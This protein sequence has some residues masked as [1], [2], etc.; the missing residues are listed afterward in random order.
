MTMWTSFRS[1]F[2]GSHVTVKVKR[3]LVRRA[4]Q[5]GLSVSRLVYRLL[6]DALKIKDEEH[7]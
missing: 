4:Q 7:A 3:A 5:E 6:K 1:E 2:V